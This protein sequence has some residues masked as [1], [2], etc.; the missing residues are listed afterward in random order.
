MKKILLV[1]DEKD[2]TEFV[3]SAFLPYREDVMFFAAMR[4]DLAME[5]ALREKPGVIAL[6]LR[7][8]GSLS[9]EKM[10]IQLKEE[11]PET[12]FMIVTAWDDGKNR[13]RIINEVGVDAYFD[14]PIELRHF[15]ETILS[16]LDIKIKKKG[17]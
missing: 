16:F 10:L 2:F 9:G 5:I 6:D 3:E 8:P 11:L 1:D 17:S 7:M 14:K 15:I 4:G 13:H 12:K